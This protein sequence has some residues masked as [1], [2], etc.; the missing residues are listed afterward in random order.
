ME[1]GNTKQ[2]NWFAVFASG[3]SVLHFSISILLWGLFFGMKISNSNEPAPWSA[4]KSVVAGIVL[5][6][7]FVAVFILAYQGQTKLSVIGLCAGVMLSILCFY[8]ETSHAMY[9]MTFPA[10]RMGGRYYVFS[11]GLREKYINWWWYEKTEYFLDVN[12]PNLK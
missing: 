11:V 12:D 3:F 8:Y 4:F 1:K 5:L 7:I 6:L 2:K 9:Q 10:S